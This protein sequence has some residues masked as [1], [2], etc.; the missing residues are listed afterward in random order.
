MILVTGASGFIGARLLADLRRQGLPCRAMRRSDDGDPATV[1]ADLTNPASLLA[2]CRG[3]HTIYHCA[4]YAHAFAAR[5]NDSQ[6]HW[7]IN[8]DGTR[9]LVE[10]AAAAG[11][12]SLVFLSSVKALAEPGEECIDEN[13]PGPPES[14]YGRA[15]RAA[16]ELLL[17]AGARE[18]MHVVI[19]RPAMVYGAGGRGNL[20][21][22][23]RMVGAGYFPPLPETAN[24]RSLIHVRDLLDVMQLVAAETRAQGRIYIVASREAPSG[25]R[26]FDALRQV[27][28]LPPIT[29]SVPR[30]FL[31]LAA[32]TG[33]LLTR[34]SGRRMPFNSEVLSRLLDSACYSGERIASEL[35]WRARVSLQQGLEEMLG[36]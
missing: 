14:D 36:K 31:T 10:A 8:F 2:A 24:R 18:G 29:W 23:A 15:K 11:V 34:Y 30:S 6:R 12:R 35:G 1:V 25:R 9:L 3:I 20:E 5:G 27:Q 28:G 21:R 4:G 16:E 17:A 22:M 13:F 33:D 26:L 32:S 19:L 7:Q